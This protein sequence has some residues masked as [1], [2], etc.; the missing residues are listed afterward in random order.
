MTYPY[1]SCGEVPSSARLET[2]VSDGGSCVRPFY[3]LFAFASWLSVCKRKIDDNVVKL[4][5][6]NYSIVDLAFQGD[7]CICI[8]QTD[9]QLANPV[10][11]VHGFW[12]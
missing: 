6:P 4:F 1:Q 2:R 10:I 5:V 12:K 11:F 9:Y 7:R 3:G 8:L